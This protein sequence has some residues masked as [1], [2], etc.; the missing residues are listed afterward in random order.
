MP[1]AGRG[2]FGGCHASR[3]AMAAIEAAGFSVRDVVRYRLPD[4]RVPWPTASHARGIAV[5][6]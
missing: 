3:D 2:V 1:P 4:T 6:S 5:R